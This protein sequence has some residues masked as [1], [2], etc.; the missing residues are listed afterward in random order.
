M[1]ANKLGM[2][3]LGE[4]V[5]MF[6]ASGR[7]KWIEL[8]DTV[9]SQRLIYNSDKKKGVRKAQ[10]FCVIIELIQLADRHISVC[11]HKK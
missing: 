10:R 8:N 1:T 4:G 11:G 9:R 6:W 3:V 7:R 2:D 5:Q